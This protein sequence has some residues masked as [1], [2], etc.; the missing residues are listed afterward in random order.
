MFI[1]YTTLELL[2]YVTC[3]KQLPWVGIWNI[4]S[5]QIHTYQEFLSDDGLQQTPHLSDA[6]DCKWLYLSHVAERGTEISYLGSGVLFS[7]R[8]IG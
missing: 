1:I 7:D 2:C 5:G 6:L 4:F 8:G 3:A